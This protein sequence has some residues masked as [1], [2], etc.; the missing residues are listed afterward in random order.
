MNEQDV[1]DI[2]ENTSKD[3]VPVSIPLVP[4]IKKEKLTNLDRNKPR[5]IHLMKLLMSTKRAYSGK[6][7]FFSLY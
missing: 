7:K 1:I 4:F 6:I 3:N 5:E 2:K